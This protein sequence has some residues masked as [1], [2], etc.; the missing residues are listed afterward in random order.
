MWCPGCK[1]DDLTEADFGKDSSNKKTGLQGYC[2]DCDRQRA[3]EWDGRNR[4]HR[5]AYDRTYYRN[6]AAKEA[7]S[8]TRWSRDNP[9]KVRDSQRRREARM[10]AVYV[11]TINELAIF[12]RDGWVC[13]L[14]CE[15]VDRTLRSP[16]PLSAT[17]DHIIP[18]TREG[19]HASA[20]VRL[21]HHRCN[22]RKGNKLDSECDWLSPPLV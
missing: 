10:R 19:P 5:H 6:N 2:R 21:A 16:H 14:C 7:T 13:Q 17:L 9:D 11:E 3:K 12:E 15:P 8:W 20:N 1:R 18:V 4:D 22:S